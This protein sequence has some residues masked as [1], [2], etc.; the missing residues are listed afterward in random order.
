MTNTVLPLLQELTHPADSHDIR[1][2]LSVLFQKEAAEDLKKMQ[3]YYMLFDELSETIR[4]RDACI[5][6]LRTNYS[7]NEVVE[8]IEI[9]RLMHL[10]DTQAAPRLMLM[11]R[12][13]QDKVHEKNRFVAR[14]R[15]M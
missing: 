5:I 10:D 2:Q 11:A 15:L 4:M 9:L 8:S 1:D 12:E 3:D 14:L 6:E 7:S 13:M